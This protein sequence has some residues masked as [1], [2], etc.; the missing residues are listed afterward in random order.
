MR[1]RFLNDS[2]Y[3]RIHHPIRYSVRYGPSWWTLRYPSPLPEIR[4]PSAEVVPPLL[5]M[6][7]DFF[8]R[9]KLKI[10]KNQLVLCCST[11]LFTKSVNILNKGFNSLLTQ[12]FDVL[13]QKF[14]DSL[15]GMC[16]LEQGPKKSRTCCTQSI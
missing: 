1:M 6:H 9:G 2:V 8:V 5:V 4:D 16:V 11:T 13:H 14:L 10:G 3:R 7:E 12:N 15:C